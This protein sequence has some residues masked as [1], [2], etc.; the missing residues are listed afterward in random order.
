MNNSKFITD[1]FNA[2]LI[3]DMWG[4]PYTDL[5]V[6]RKHIADERWITLKP[7]GPENKGTPVKISGSGEILAGMGG[8]FNG[9]NIKE[10]DKPPIEKQRESQGSNGSV[11]K[12]K[13][14]KKQYRP[15]SHDEVHTSL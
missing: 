10:M 7:N 6:L 9:R 3:Q 13:G 15:L 8:K 14:S 12:S 4:V 11:G 1:A 5:S 2:G